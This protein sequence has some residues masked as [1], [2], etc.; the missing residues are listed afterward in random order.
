M[1]SDTSDASSE[2]ADSIE[3]SI[4]E[5]SRDDSGSETVDDSSEISSDDTDNEPSQKIRKL[6]NSNESNGTITHQVHAVLNELKNVLMNFV[7]NFQISRPPIIIVKTKNVIMQI[8]EIDINIIYIFIIRRMRLH[9]RYMTAKQFIQLAKNC[10][11]NHRQ[12]L[13]NSKRMKLID[14]IYL[15]WKRIH[16][17]FGQKKRP[18]R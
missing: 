10:E 15:L 12:K 5:S 8:K 9:F 6:S 2:L 4:D 3:D 18:S 17:R 11:K 7:F 14:Q 13:Q 1:S 16:L